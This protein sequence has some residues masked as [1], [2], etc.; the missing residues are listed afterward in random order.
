M[1]NARFGKLSSNLKKLRNA[2]F[3]IKAKFELKEAA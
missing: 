3:L 1:I 2:R